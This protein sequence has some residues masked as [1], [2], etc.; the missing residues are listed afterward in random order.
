MQISFTGKVERKLLARAMEQT[1]L[2]YIISFM[3]R[4]NGRLMDGNTVNDAIFSIDDN[5]SRK[6]IC[7]MANC[8]HPDIL[9]KALSNNFNQTTLVGQRFHGIKANTSALSPEELDDSVEL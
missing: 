4:D 3:L 9:Y 6:P 5:V 2:P 1:A 7:Y 8:I